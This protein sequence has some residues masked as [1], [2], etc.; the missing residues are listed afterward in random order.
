MERKRLKRKLNELEECSAI[1]CR[2]I[3]TCVEGRRTGQECVNVCVSISC[4]V[5]QELDG[6]FEKGSPADLEEGGLAEPLLSVALDGK[7]MLMMV[8]SAA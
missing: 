4:H 2:A 5:P 1:V 8:D 6:Q 7:T 3:F